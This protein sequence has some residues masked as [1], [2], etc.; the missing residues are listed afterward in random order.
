MER[1]DC[2]D[3]DLP[4]AQEHSIRRQIAYENKQA[5]G[6]AEPSPLFG[7]K[8]H[9]LLQGRVTGQEDADGGVHRED[10]KADRKHKPC[11]YLSQQHRQDAGHPPH[12][13]RVDQV[14]LVG[15]QIAEQVAPHRV[16]AVSLDRSPAFS[17]GTA[18]GIGVG[19]AQQQDRGQTADC[20]DRKKEGR[21]AQQKNCG[22]QDRR[23]KRPQHTPQAFSGIDA[24]GHKDGTDPAQDASRNLHPAPGGDRQ[25]HGQQSGG[26]GE[27]RICPQGSRI[28]KHK[29]PVLKGKHKHIFH[30]GPAVPG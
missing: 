25:H 17:G 26:L 10:A 5:V 27:Q 29:A 16:T 1:C 28:G 8:P 18:E 14:I 2:A 12:S 21:S 23:P 22:K 13:R 6:G 3:L 19:P 15:R 30:V 24:H 9:R 11:L 7:Q 20:Q 4:A